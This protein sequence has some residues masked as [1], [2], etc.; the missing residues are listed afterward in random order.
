MTKIQETDKA[1]RDLIDSPQTHFWIANAM[2]TAMTKD[3]VDAVGNF[4]VAAKLFSD[5]LKAMQ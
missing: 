4:E 5:R 3:P 2:R 1:I